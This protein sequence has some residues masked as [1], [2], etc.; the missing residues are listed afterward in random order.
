MAPSIINSGLIIMSIEKMITD[1]DLKL[2]TLISKEKKLSLK[3]LNWLPLMDTI[4]MQLL[5]AIMMS[6]TMSTMMNIMM[7]MI[8]M[9]SIT[10]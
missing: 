10:D 6:I 4:I 9:M 2:K 1:G 8:L 5:T 7:I 3:R